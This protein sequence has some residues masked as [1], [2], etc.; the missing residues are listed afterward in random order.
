MANDATQQ[1]MINN[2]SA[3]NLLAENKD[4]KRIKKIQGKSEEQLGQEVRDRELNQLP[5]KT[6]GDK[7]QES[8]EYLKDPETETDSELE[9]R[10]MFSNE[11]LRKTMQILNAG[12]TTYNN[13]KKIPFNVLTE[14]LKIG[15][16][17]LG[18]NAYR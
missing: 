12:I 9:Q 18:I 2:N 10:Q 7:L 16:A 17:G 5:P 4:W 11:D 15:G 14:M 1:L 3:N 6:E 13:V 8:G